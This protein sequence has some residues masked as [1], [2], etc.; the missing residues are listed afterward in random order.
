MKNLT[1]QNLYV[2]TSSTDGTVDGSQVDGIN[3]SGALTHGFTVT[4]NTMH[5]MG[6]AILSQFQNGTANVTISGNNIYNVDHGFALTSNA[7]S[8]T[9]TIGT[10]I[11]SGNHLHDFANWDTAA[12]TYHHDGIHCFTGLGAGG[13]FTHLTG[14]Y[15]YNNRLDGN[16]G[17]NMNSPIFLEGGLTTGRT[18]CS[19]STSKI[20]VFNNVFQANNFMANGMMRLASGTN[21]SIYNNTYV[22]AGTSD[23]RYLGITTETDPGASSVA[24]ENNVVSS[25]NNL[26]SMNGTSQFASGQPTHNIWADS[27]TNAFSCNG[28][29]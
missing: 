17:A 12:D 10:I 2:H 4:N 28:T 11:F 3:V 15:I 8:A 18:P 13:F 20:Y 1:I 5:D 26:V 24:M 25:C 16:T 9:Q 27:G 21:V 23:P 22:C 19:D 29:I 6:W 14:F 7:T